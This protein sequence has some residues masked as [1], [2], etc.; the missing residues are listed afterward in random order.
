[1]RLVVQAWDLGWCVPLTM[2]LCPLGR[3]LP[4]LYR[5]ARFLRLSRVRCCFWALG[6]W[7]L[8]EPFV[9]ASST[10]RVQRI[11]LARPRGARLDKFGLFPPSSAACFFRRKQ[12][13]FLFCFA[14]STVS[15]PPF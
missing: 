10:A 2:W 12:A 7:V 9:V 11:G 5:R 3:P 8:A 1:M 15:F 13:A 14:E 4:R 6:S